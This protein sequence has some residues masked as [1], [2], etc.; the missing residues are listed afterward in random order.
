MVVFQETSPGRYTQHKNGITVS[1]SPHGSARDMRPGGTS[2]AVQV[3][4]GSTSSKLKHDL[5]WV[6]TFLTFLF[7]YIYSRNI[8]RFYVLDIF[9][10]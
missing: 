6:F 2:S 1:G 7:Q 5:L 4:L 3:R 8:Y 10:C 9:G